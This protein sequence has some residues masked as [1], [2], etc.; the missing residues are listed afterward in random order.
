MDAFMSEINDNLFPIVES[1]EEAVIRN[2]SVHFQLEICSVSLSEVNQEL[3][4]LLHHSR[5]KIDY[6]GGQGFVKSLK[7]KPERIILI[8]QLLGERVQTFQS[9]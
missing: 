8:R 2:V 4:R 7:Y 3:S 1:F 9:F 6:L 5:P